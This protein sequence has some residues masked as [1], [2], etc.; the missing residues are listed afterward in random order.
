MTNPQPPTEARADLGEVVVGVLHKDGNFEKKASLANHNKATTREV[1][2]EVL[3]ILC[4]EYDNDEDRA[5]FKQIIA[6]QIE[7]TGLGKGGE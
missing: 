5:A 4:D 3:E 6:K 7:K 2:E 1:L